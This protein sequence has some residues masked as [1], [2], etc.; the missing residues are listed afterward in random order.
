M[1][2]EAVLSEQNQLLADQ[3][4]GDFADRFE[5]L[6][7]KAAEDAE[8]IQRLETAVEEATEKLK[9]REHHGDA[10]V[11]GAE[12]A[13]K[14]D[15][16][17]KAFNLHRGLVGWHC[18]F[19]YDKTPYEDHSNKEL[20]PERDILNEATKKAQSAGVDTEG[21]FAV[22][23]Q[24][25]TEFIP[26]LLSKLTAGELG[27]QFLDGLDGTPVTWPRV[28]SGPESYWVGENV[29]PAESEAVIGQVSMTPHTLA[30][31]V[32][33][34]NRL[35]AQTQGR[36]EK[37]LTELIARKKAIKLEQAI[38]KGIGSAAQPL[39]L[40]NSPGIGTTAWGSVTKSGAAQDV[41][42]LISAMVEGVD[43]SNALEGN[44]GWVAHPQVHGFL[45][46]AK[47]ADGK[48]LFT[49]QG[50][51]ETPSI[52]MLYNYKLLKTTQLAS[53][54][55]ADLMF[56]NWADLMVGQWGTMVIDTSKE[57]GNAFFRRQTYFRAYIDVDIAIMHEA[58]FN[59]AT[60]FNASA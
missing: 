25:N 34:S 49:L 48:P 42:D 26:L 10:F 17:A 54:N 11:E 8:T 9:S 23:E 51:P 21:G 13:F 31:L 39:G 57:A 44:L 56:G 52:P 45:R 33:V 58:S 28:D 29:A 12:D 2:P 22:P 4:K 55:P 7:T 32:P 1:P 40:A 15:D 53:G 50:N 18:D 36:F 24:F 43:T 3:L 14:T 37:M 5:A 19:D 46:E 41:T 60:G 27:V 6:E 35:I 30:T 59:V 47:D 38:Y 16:P 20:W